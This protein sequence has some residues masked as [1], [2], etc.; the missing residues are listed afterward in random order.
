M[1]IIWWQRATT[2]KATTLI[3]RARRTRRIIGPYVPS[4][5]VPEIPAWLD[6]EDDPQRIRLVRLKAQA[7]RQADQGRAQELE[8][9]IRRMVRIIEELEEEEEDA[10]SILLMH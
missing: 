2:A 8:R 1:L 6:T 9:T 4:F 7:E 5:T 10:I 3:G